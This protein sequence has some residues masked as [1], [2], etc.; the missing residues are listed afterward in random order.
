MLIHVSMILSL[1]LLI[2]VL[3]TVGKNK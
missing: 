1:I 3:V 2:I